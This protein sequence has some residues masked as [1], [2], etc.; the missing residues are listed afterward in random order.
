[1]A[2]LIRD[3]LPIDNILPEIV[4]KLF[5]WGALVLSAEP[6][7]GKTTRVPPAILDSG[8]ATIAGKSPGQI[9][10]LQ[11]R[12]VA[13][14]A[15]ASRMSEERG[16]DVGAEI[17]YQV[18][19]ERRMSRYTRILV[20]T[21]G[22]FIRRLQ[23]DPFLENVAVVIF[24]EFHER[25]LDS[26]LALAMV[27]QVRESV[28]PDLRILVMSAT[29]DADP[30][31][32]YLGQCATL[33]SEGRMH[34]VAIEYLQFPS[35]APIEQLAADG[36]RQLFART[37]GHLLAFLPGVGEIRRTQGILET[38]DWDGRITILPLY[39]DLPLEE[40]QRVLRPSKDRKIILATNVAETSL[41][42]DGVT[43]V[44][45][46]G[47]ARVNR[48]DPRLGLNRLGLERIAKSSA[49]QRSG[50]AGRTAPGE[51]LRLWTEREQ[52]MLPDFATAEISR[53][54]LSECILQLIAWGE[55]D[56]RAFPWFEPPPGT[57][58]DRALELLDRLDALQDGRLTE[59][60]KRMARFP[61]QPR[62]ARLL[63]KGQ[64]FGEPERAALSAALLSERD[65]FRRS[66]T[67]RQAMH[68][69]NSDVVDRLGAIEQFERTQLRDS[70][71]GE[72]LTGPAKQIM[73][74]SKQLQ[75][76]ATEVDS[77]T[78]PV[79]MCTD[80]DEPI[81]R[82]LAA[83]FPDRICKRREPKGR[84]AVMVGGRG[85]R[86]ADDSAVA[87]GDLFVAIEFIDTTNQSEL[88]VRQASIVDR[89][90]L[91]ES[92]LSTSTEVA[93]DPSR[94]KVIAMKRTRFC[95]LVIDESQ[96]A[97][98]GGTDPG[99]ILA[100]AV[101]SRFDLASLVDDEAKRY[102]TRL[103][104]L[105]KW[106]PELEL[107]DLTDDPWRNLLPEWCAGCSSVA[108]LR[109]T[110]LVSAIK[111][112]LTP[113]QIAE[114]DREA[115]DRIAVPS[116]Q[117]I[118]LDYAADQPPVLAVRIQELFGLRE[119]P[120]I[121]RSRVPVLLQLL[122]PNYRPQQI[123]NDLA[124]FWKNTYAEV[125]KDLKARYPKHA[126]PEDPLN[127]QPERGPKRR[128]QG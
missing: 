76:L 50:R 14:R 17:G 94:E 114:I 98:P 38:A 99:A 124:S 74:A 49:Q 125:K 35:S 43:A 103:Q 122:A 81:L 71:V 88:L 80:A 70:V 57:A 68:H 72:L 36:V 62:L 78:E 115:P 123:T 30:V 9:I 22:V 28:R 18:R 87:E 2:A 66:E 11:P 54:E 39:G 117:S 120:K 116:G 4:E 45:D 92:H 61:L 91:P 102:L 69:S 118:K 110:S 12:R 97:L 21:E 121:A 111:A 107:P 65:P 67:R 16:T 24:D 95:D 58:V 55:S 40:Q 59:L 109:S 101:A 100:E 41:T 73:Q 82:A 26:D 63:L 89:T 93:F 20:S 83:A 44:V 23:E 113:Q 3:A 104:C 56:V 46:S 96:T 85:V 106:I 25:S 8:M 112:H 64:Q 86:L 105:R 48:F 79:R 51:C 77:K 32:N 33:H 128:S 108:E 13:A 19:H 37:G 42:I 119:T 1:V 29:L 27:R 84:R 75:R 15:A 34:P 90:W 31:A 5:S 47:F 60:G 6:G 7:A 126:W 52:Q 10:V 53:V 127:A